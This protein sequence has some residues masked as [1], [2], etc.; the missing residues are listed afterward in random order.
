MTI[1][2]VVTGFAR[3]KDADLEQ[4]AQYIL[5]SLTGNA[6]FPNPT[7]TFFCT[8]TCIAFTRFV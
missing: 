7:L 6:N 8:P 2:K 5:V 3:Y 1:Q 4:K